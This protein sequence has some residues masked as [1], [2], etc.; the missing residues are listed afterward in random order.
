MSESTST[1]DLVLRGGRV[2]TAGADGRADVGVRDGRVVALGTDLGRG[3]EEIDAGGKLVLPGGFDAHV[4][5]TPVSMPGRSLA[6]AD[7]FDTG[8]RAAAAGGVTTVGDITFGRVG[9]SL[10]S[11]LDRVAD[12]ASRRAQVDFVLHPVLVDPSPERRTE[13]AQL[14]EGGVTSVKMF[15]HM[16]GFDERAGEYLDALHAAGQAG[17]LTLIHCED[18]GIID[19]C[20]G[21][22]MRDGHA[23][24]AHFPETR[25]V[26]SEVAAVERA[27]AYATAAGAPIYLVHISSKEALD[28]AARARSRGVPVYVETRPIYLHFTRDRFDGPDPGLYV[29]N[30]PLRETADIDAL[31]TGLE[32]G[33]V[34]TCCTDHAPWSR[35][36]KLDPTMD[37]AHTRPGMADLETLMPTLFSSGVR[38]GRLSLQRFV[39]VTS[40]NAARLFGVYPHKGTIAVGSDADLVVWDPDLRRTVRSEDLETAAKLSLFDGQELTG[41]PVVTISRGVVVAR[42]SRAVGTAGHGRRVVRA[43]PAEPPAGTEL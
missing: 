19:H 21:R 22:L 43:Q 13:L 12:D 39:E 20:T 33:T 41:W 7:D 11:A 26:G 4:H 17:L 37:V 28:A 29:G 36:Q 10:V 34:S 23:D 24:L 31:W 32:S 15:M 3:A 5:F 8:T 1:Y 38:T 18:R 25:P 30:P 42:N 9:E 16:G 14:A 6:W 27:I 2:V 35:E 40:A